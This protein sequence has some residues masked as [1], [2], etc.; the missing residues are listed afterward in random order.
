SLNLRGSF[1][2]RPL[3]VVLKGVYS[4]TGDSEEGLAAGW[5]IG[6]GNLLKV[7]SVAAVHIPIGHFHE[8]GSRLRLADDFGRC[9][10]PFL[11]IK[12]HSDVLTRVKFGS[13]RAEYLRL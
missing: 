2:S 5:S 8:V 10:P 6:P 9:C 11:S 7:T 4:G 3:E 12:F 13:G 1:I